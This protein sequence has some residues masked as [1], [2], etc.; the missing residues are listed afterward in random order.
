[1]LRLTRLGHVNLAVYVV[2]GCLA[3]AYWSELG[4]AWKQLPDYLEDRIESPLERRLYREAAESIYAQDDVTR[5]RELLD[6]SI[7]IDT[8]GEAVY[9]LAVLLDRT[10][11]DD[12]AVEQFTRY[13]EI[14]P[15]RLDAYLALAAIHRRNQRFHDAQQALQTGIDYFDSTVERYLPRFDDMVDSDFNEKAEE[16][17]EDYKTA[18]QV[19][20]QRVEVIDERLSAL[21]DRAR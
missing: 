3:V 21:A 16:V 2:I 1:M 18:A 8:Y 5:A 17:Y 14:D 4:W 11:R 19:L 6:R 15:T 10:R 20:R 9:W 7:E 12:A 13:L